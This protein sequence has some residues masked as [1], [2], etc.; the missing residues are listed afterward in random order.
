VADVAFGLR[1]CFFEADAQVVLALFGLAEAPEPFVHLVL[2]VVVAARLAAH[3]H[4][5]GAGLLEIE[6]VHH[7]GAGADLF[8]DLPLVDHFLPRVGA[9]LGR[10][11]ADPGVAGQGVVRADVVGQHQRVMVLVV[12]EVVVDA[13]VLH[14]AA[15][16]GEVV[17]ADYGFAF[18]AL[19]I[20]NAPVLAS[21]RPAHVGRRAVLRACRHGL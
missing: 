14:Q 19:C 8:G 18:D 3:V 7:V 10:E 11:I 4:Q 21:S 6:I 5:V 17:F 15:H 2:A 1:L 9:A 13:F 16:E 20:G 12:R